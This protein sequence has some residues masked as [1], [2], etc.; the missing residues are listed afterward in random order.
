MVQP[1]PESAAT[2]PSLQTPGDGTPFVEPDVPVND[3]CDGD[4][5]AQLGNGSGWTLR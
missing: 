1:A 5:S 2:R 3:P 4:Q